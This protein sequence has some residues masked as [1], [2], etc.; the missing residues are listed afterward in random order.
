MRVAPG[1]KAFFRVV[2]DTQR[3]CAMKD[4]RF[5]ARFRNSERQHQQGKKKK[6]H[7]CHHHSYLSALERLF[8]I[9]TDDPLPSKTL[10]T[11]SN[12]TEKKAQGF[13]IVRNN[14]QWRLHPRNNL[15]R[16]RK[17]TSPELPPKTSS[18]TLLQLPSRRLHL[19]LLRLLWLVRVLL[20]W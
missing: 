3:F 1:G 5:L 18:R 17:C 13:S 8:H 12:S 20:L 16:T 14:S 9:Q 4:F 6:K 11:R 2:C 10:E 7:L 19:L 15:L